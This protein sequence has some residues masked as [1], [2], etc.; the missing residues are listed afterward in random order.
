M[1]LTLSTLR[2]HTPRK[3]KKRLGRG[4]AAGKGTY[5]GRG[6]KGQK[7]RSGGK[8][9]G[10]HAGKKTPAFVR[11]MKKRRGFNSGNAGFVA[12]NLKDLERFDA[13]TT[14]SPKFLRQQNLLPNRSAK[15]KV[16][17]YGTLSKKLTVQ[18][19]A[20]SNAAADAITKAGGKAVVLRLGKPEASAE[21]KKS[22]KSE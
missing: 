4:N 5:S 2:R 17:G 3:S 16:L 10:G 11:Q 8:H 20:F 22:K 14:I 12:V 13:D 15:V 19:H 1:T 6:I 18:A 7:S 9:A 21:T